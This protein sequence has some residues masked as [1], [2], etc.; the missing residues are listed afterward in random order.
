LRSR[1][2][3]ESMEFSARSSEKNKKLHQVVNLLSYH[4]SCGPHLKNLSP[5]LHLEDKLKTENPQSEF[6]SLIRA[7]KKLGRL[8]Q[9]DPSCFSSSPRPPLPSRILFTANSINYMD[10]I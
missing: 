8:L 10:E 4:Q 5:P 3:V 6:L 7:L 9:L 2:S 1:S